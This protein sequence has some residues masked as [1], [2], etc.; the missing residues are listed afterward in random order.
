MVLVP[1]YTLNPNGRLSRFSC[2]GSNGGFPRLSPAVMFRYSSHDF[3]VRLCT[4]NGAISILVDDFVKRHYL[5]HLPDIAPKSRITTSTTTRI[6]K[7]LCRATP[8]NTKKISSRIKSNSRTSIYL[9][10][11]GS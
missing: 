3:F 10:F 1:K 4:G 6:Q 9:S 11:F 2:D 5:V 8:P 7:R